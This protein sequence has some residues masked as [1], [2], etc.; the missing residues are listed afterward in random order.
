MTR[1]ETDAQ[2]LKRLEDNGMPPVDVDGPMWR[3]YL[4]GGEKRRSQLAYLLVVRLRNAQ[5]K[6][7]ARETQTH[8]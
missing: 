3:M 6:A 2:F 5:A 1:D 8:D 4:N 7:R